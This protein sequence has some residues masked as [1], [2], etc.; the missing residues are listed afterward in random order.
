MWFNPGGNEMSDTEWASPFVRCLGMLLSGDTND[1]LNFQGEVV[2][3]ETFLVL[4]NAHYE[5]IPFMLPGQEHLEWE[6]ILDTHE[7]SGFLASPKKFG[8][9]DDFDLVERSTALFRLTGGEQARAREESWRKRP[10][11]LPEEISAE[12]ERAG[13]RKR[14]QA[15]AEE[16]SPEN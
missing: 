10:I 9:G 8:S 2:H 14:E 6:L 13:T 4:L 11:R 5:P 7:E 16:G 3:D 12:E 1:I 15:A